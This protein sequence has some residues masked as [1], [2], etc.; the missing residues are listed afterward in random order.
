MRE[1]SILTDVGSMTL[2][3]RLRYMFE[4]V[5]GY[6]LI[7]SRN[8]PADFNLVRAEYINTRVR[9]LALL[10]SILTPLWIPVDYFI[11][12]ES[13]FGMMAAARLLFSLSLLALWVKASYVF[14][15][16]HA[17]F[18]LLMLMVIPALFHLSAQFILGEHLSDARLASYTFLPFL[19][20]TIHCVFPLTLREGS[21]L[22]LITIFTLSLDELIQRQMFTLASLN[23]LWLLAVIMSI[24]IWA[25][26]SQ[27]HM[28][29]KLFEQA[30][31]DALTGLLTRRAFMSLA[32]SELSRSERYNR[33]LT[34][35]L[36][37]LDHFKV[38]NDTYGHQAGD[39]VL[40]T[41]SRQLK[42]VLRA[43]DIIGRYGGEEFI[44]VLPETRLDEAEQVIQRVLDTCRETPVQYGN[45]SIRLTAS[46]GLGEVLVDV[47]TSILYIDEAL[48]QAKDSGRDRI[49]KV[50]GERKLLTE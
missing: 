10:F 2:P 15:L 17:R 8:H 28:Q 50:A 39:K 12:P 23:N 43:T 48:Y 16:R 34:M 21:L 47:Q 31:T 4:Q 32:E 44:I 40:V 5:R 6:E 24:A 22:A 33:T 25:Q 26:L 1:K 37:D 9:V 46:A 18:R 35:A 14:S 13:S 41:F 38:I 45:H 27:L 30:T 36:L 49:I 29:L 20:I 7:G 42:D 11:L 19:I 3:H